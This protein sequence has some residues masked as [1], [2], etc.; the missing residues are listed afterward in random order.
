MTT[1]RTTRRTTVRP[2]SRLIP[3]VIQ[4]ESE[5]AAPDNLRLTLSEA[6]ATN[7]ATPT[8]TPA[9]VTCGACFGRAAGSARSMTTG[10][11]QAGRSGG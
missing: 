10:S 6:A 8:K 5:E 7:C 4:R 11:R 3:F 9:I 1:T 2:D